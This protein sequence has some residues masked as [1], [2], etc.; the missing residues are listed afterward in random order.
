M[1]TTKQLGRIMKNILMGNDAIALALIHANVD[2]V[3]GYPGT[4]SSEILGNFQNLKIN[5]E[6]KLMP[7]GQQMKKL[8]LK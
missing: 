2:M 8:V 3:S 5:L 1:V 4:P 7:N 6:L